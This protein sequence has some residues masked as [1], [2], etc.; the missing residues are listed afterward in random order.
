MSNK[1][2]DGNSIM[3]FG[4]FAGEQMKR[5]PNH[6]LEWLLDQDWISKR[7]RLYH[8]LKSEED[9]IRANAQRDRNCDATK[10]DIY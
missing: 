4:K 10:I 6:Y 7:K 3:S 1:G 5:I 8:Y 2:M 9:Y